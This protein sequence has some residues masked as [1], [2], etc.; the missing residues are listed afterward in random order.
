MAK[1]PPRQKMPEQDPN[2]RID[3]FEEVAL[4]FTEEMVKKEA[5]RC[6]QCDEPKC[7]NGCPVNIDIPDFIKLIKENNY[8]EAIRSIKNYNILPA[9]CG[10]VCPQENQ[11][12]K[13]CILSKKWEPVAIGALERFLADWEIKNQLKEC[14]D[15]EAPNNIKVAWSPDGRY[16]SKYRSKTLGFRLV[17]LMN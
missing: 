4:G 13:A 9:I 16:R 17:M 3:N 6:L 11:C 14:P 7:V 12:E 8:L 1:I 2:I 10:R 15:C 5:E